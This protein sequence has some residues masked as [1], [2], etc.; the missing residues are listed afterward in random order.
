MNISKAA[1]VYILEILQHDDAV[2]Y[3]S[4]AKELIDQYDITL[5]ESNLRK[6]LSF[7]HQTLNYINI[8]GNGLTL[9]RE[10][11]DKNG[12]VLGQVHALRKNNT[13]DVS[14][15]E[16]VGVTKTPF[17]SNFVKYKKKD[18]GDLDFL[19]DED[20]I[21]ELN[22]KLTK[23]IKPIKFKK[24]KTTKNHLKIVVSDRHIGAS[25]S[26]NSIYKND[27]NKDVYTKRMMRVLEEV[28]NLQKVYGS[29]DDITYLDLGDVL[30]GFDAMTTRKGHTLPQNMNNRE[31]FDT[32][33]EVEKMFFDSLID[34][35]KFNNISYNA[36]SNDN[37]SGDAG[38]A[39]FRAFE[40]YANA[41]YPQM[42]TNITTKFLNHI[43]IED[44]T[45]VFTHGKDKKD[46]KFGLPLHLDLKT[47]SYIRQYI[48]H[49]SLTGKITF[50]KGDLHQYSHNEGKK[51]SYVNVPSLFGSSEWI[52]NNFGN[53]KAG[54][55]LE[56]NELQ[57]PFFF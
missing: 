16:I 53:T 5:S 15:M 52:H 7:L 1:Y 54:F 36:I 31:Q 43:K 48:D 42:K 28:N 20:Y 41:K 2:N 24:H 3:T 10:N 45:I 26:L 27:Y 23:G 57:K 47:E 17:G 38:Y 22:Q 25:V 9:V 6:S 40:L 44:E 51:F 50:I 35:V 55:Y 32:F 14:G 30:D 56:I 18:S 29:F 19:H 34:T 12:D 37:H 46:R 11:T 8:D 21:K 49:Y 33:V 4:L 39:A 13:V